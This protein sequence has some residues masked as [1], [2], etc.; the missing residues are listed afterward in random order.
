MEVAAARISTIRKRVINAWCMYDWANS[1]YSLVISSTIFPI[2]YS[3]TTR[4]EGTNHMVSYFGIS[5]ENT[6]LYSYSIS[7]AFLIV[8]FISPLLSGIADYGGKRKGFMKM[9][10]YLGGFS[11]AMLYFF[12]GKN[13]EWGINFS[14]LACLGYAGSL[15][16]Y[17][18]YLP[19]ITSQN[20]YDRV[21]AKGYSL[22]YLGSVLLL[23]LILL[24]LFN[25][26]SFGFSGDAQATRFAFILVGLWWIGFAQYSF[27]YLP[28]NQKT[29]TSDKHLFT[30]GYQEIV[31]VWNIVKK[32]ANIL[33]YLLAFFFYNTGVQTVMYLAALFGEKELSL[34]ADKLISTILIIQLVAIGGAYLFARISERKGNVFSLSVMVVIWILIC[35]YAYFI[36]NFHQ[37]IFL[38]TVVGLVM[39]GI[40]SLS[41]ATYSKLIPRNTLDHTSFF[42]FYDA[43]DKISIVLGAFLY[44]LIEQLT[45]SMRNSTV[46]LGVLF[47][48]GLLVLYRVKVQKASIE[49]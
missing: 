24:I 18:S 3:A 22:G 49:A 12:N 7:F 25:P 45:G 11:C 33:K 46:A 48:F 13:I 38:A 16:F 39:G 35:I 40:Q 19:T 44:G 23:I 36:Q 8:A 37:F 42:S 17:N 20:N 21:S 14:I 34:S 6:V 10:T 43:I 28:R 47:V 32:D 1:V 15:V 31:K 9:F 27:Y 41:R 5:V 2:Y 29:G 26:G 30:K 4:N